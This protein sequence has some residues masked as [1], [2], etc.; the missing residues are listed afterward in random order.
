[1]RLRAEACTPVRR[2]DVA[3]RVSFAGNSAMTEERRRFR[4]GRVHVVCLAARRASRSKM[5]PTDSCFPTL[6]ET[7]TRTRLLPAS[8]LRAFARCAPGE[9]RPPRPRNR[10][11]HDARNASGGRLGRGAYSSL[12][13][14]VHDFSW[15]SL[16]SSVCCALR[17]N[18]LPDDTSVAISPRVAPVVTACSAGE[19]ARS[20]LPRRP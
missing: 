13:G 11:L 10:A 2:C 15:R 16:A 1:M 4:L 3:V 5:C 12:R 18:D 20:F 9:L 19:A 6:Y 14:P 17:A 7:R 8:S